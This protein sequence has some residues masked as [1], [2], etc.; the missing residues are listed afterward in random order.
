MWQIPTLSLRQSESKNDGFC[1]AM[2]LVVTRQFKEEYE[3][4]ERHLCIW[5][6]AEVKDE[7]WLKWQ[8]SKRLECM[9][10]I[11]P[12]EFAGYEPSRAHGIGAK[13]YYSTIFEK[14]N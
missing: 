8:E 2:L 6:R 14:N 11:I 5:Y 10:S 3:M 1:A 4:N 7:F 9:E 12:L 13:T